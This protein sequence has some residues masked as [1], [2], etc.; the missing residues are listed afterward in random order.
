MYSSVAAAG[1]LPDAVVSYLD[2]TVGLPILTSY[3]LSRHEPRPQKRLYDR[4]L[5]MLERL[6]TETLKWGRKSKIADFFED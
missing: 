4:R 2:A 1:R 3:A 6:K 5:D